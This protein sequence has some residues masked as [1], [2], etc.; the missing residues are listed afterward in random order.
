MIKKHQRNI[1][2]NNIKRL[3]KRFRLG[4]FKEFDFSQSYLRHNNE[5]KEGEAIHREREHHKKNLI[6]ALSKD[7]KSSPI[8]FSKN[9][10]GNILDNKTSIKKIIDL[11][12]GS[13]WFVNFVEENYS[14]IEYIYAIEPSYNAIEISKNIY[15]EKSKI[16]Y[17][18]EYAHI[19]LQNIK[20]DKYIITT[21]VVFLHLPKLYTKKLLKIIDKICEKDSLLVFYE[22]IG[23]S[24]L[25]NYYLHNAKSRKFWKKN[26][27][28]FQVSFEK[29]NLIFAKKVTS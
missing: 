5:Y 25:N 26:L 8:Y 7:E 24:F 27:K 22:P 13:G 19:C 10:I 11:G 3:I 23:S 1:L 4:S 29:D 28:N 18:N 16:N 21:H 15:G 12:S 17:L 6:Y 2:K 14:F 20:K 9:S